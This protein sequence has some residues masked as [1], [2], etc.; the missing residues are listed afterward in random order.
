VIFKTQT[1]TLLLVLKNTLDQHVFKVEIDTLKHH[2]S[3]EHEIAKNKNR[4]Y[5]VRTF[6]VDLPNW[7]FVKIGDIGPRM[8][9]TNA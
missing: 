6:E 4:N 3:N 8:R 1:F 2:F 9:P 7:W 5:F